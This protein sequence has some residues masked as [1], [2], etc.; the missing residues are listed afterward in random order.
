MLLKGLQPKT[1]DGYARA[2]R[3]IGTHFDHQVTSLLLQ[4]LA[5]CFTAMKAQHSWRG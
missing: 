5:D 4:Q 1:I 2:I 3:R